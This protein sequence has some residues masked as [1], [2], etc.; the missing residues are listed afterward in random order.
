MKTLNE[1]YAILS[2]PVKRREYDSLRERYGSSAYEYYRQAHSQE[3]IFRGSDIEQIFQEF[4]RSFGFR[5]PDEIFREFYGSGFQ[6][7]EYNRPGFIF[8]SYAYNPTQT[9]ELGTSPLSPLS[10]LGCAGKLIKFI[11]EKVFRI[12]IPEQGKDLFDVLKI[13]PEIAR[14]GGEVKYRHRKGENPKDLMIKIPAGIKSK[15][16]IRLRGMGLPGKA[17]GTPGDLLLRASIKIPLFQ[18][19]RSFFKNQSAEG[20][21]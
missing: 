21:L 3:D 7:Y 16:T 5:N 18:I 1:A 20:K 6:S 10:Q 8:R 9:G 15:Q 12:Q 4:S 11:L 2:D 19:I 13:T 14:Q 17:G